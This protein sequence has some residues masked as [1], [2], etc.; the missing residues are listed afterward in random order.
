MPEPMP[1]VSARWV[2][3]VPSIGV[4]SLYPSPKIKKRLDKD[5][6][7]MYSM[8][9]HIKECIHMRHNIYFPEGVFER[10]K[11]SAIGGRKSVSRYLLDLYLKEVELKEA[12]AKKVESTWA[13]GYS[14]ERQ[15]GKKEKV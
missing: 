14:K 3:S 8:D 5:T 12:I 11:E 7:S 2:P 15:L 9:T 10:I 13:G 1:I 4:V 6:H